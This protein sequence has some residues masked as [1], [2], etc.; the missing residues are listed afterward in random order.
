MATEIRHIYVGRTVQLSLT[1]PF[2]IA[3]VGPLSKQRRRDHL[4]YIANRLSRT[5]KFPSPWQLE[6]IDK[7]AL[8]YLKLNYIST[9]VTVSEVIRKEALSIL[10]GVEADLQIEEK[11][12]YYDY[13]IGVDHIVITVGL[14]S[15]VSNSTILKIHENSKIVLRK[16]A[17][18]ELNFIH[19]NWRLL[20]RVLFSIFMEL[21]LAPD[22]WLLKDTEK[23]A[24]WSENLILFAHK[25]NGPRRSKKTLK[26]I[27]YLANMVSGVRRDYDEIVVNFPGIYASSHGFSGNFALVADEAAANR[28][29]ALWNFLAMYWIGFYLANQGIYLRL[30]SLDL[31]NQDFKSSMENI[32]KI[33]NIRYVFNL[34]V[35][36][37]LP[38]SLCGN[39]FDEAIYE[40]Q[41]R[42]WKLDSL[43][44]SLEQ[45][46]EAFSETLNDIRNELG[47][48]IERRIDRILLIINILTGVGVGLQAISFWDFDNTIIEKS[49]RIFAVLLLLMVFGFGTALY[50]S[51]LASRIRSAKER[52]RP[53][54]SDL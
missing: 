23:L 48:L 6:S 38:E 32:R 29:S 49:L 46:L 26:F 54:T 18:N 8:A 7:T 13:G 47:Q 20:S 53:T 43:I 17:E 27:S 22:L 11:I 19:N 45:R 40:R 1:V 24:G 2:W 35:H 51:R 4:E 21:D 5:G 34:M 42:A 3:Q 36:E 31:D 14:H 25:E 16:I 28:V 52:N 39:T 33:K 10:Q 50:A 37:A 41:W 15:E 30:A 12:F 44:S 9:Q